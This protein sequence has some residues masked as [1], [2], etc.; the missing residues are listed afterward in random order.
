MVNDPL[1]SRQYRGFLTIERETG[2]KPVKDIA[3]GRDMIRE[4][5]SEIE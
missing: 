1:S 4:I 2:E 5:L 3:A